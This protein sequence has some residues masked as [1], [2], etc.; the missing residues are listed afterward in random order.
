MQSLSVDEVKAIYAAEQARKGVPDG[1]DPKQSTRVLLKARLQEI[2]PVPYG[3]QVLSEAQIASRRGR[4]KPSRKEH[5]EHV[6]A[7]RSAVTEEDHAAF[8]RAKGTPDAKDVLDAHHF[9]Q[10]MH[11]KSLWAE[12]DRLIAEVIR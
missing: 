9:A 12:T 1:F 10:K 7:M 6:A 8:A 3:E 11:Q 4:P 5:A 2:N